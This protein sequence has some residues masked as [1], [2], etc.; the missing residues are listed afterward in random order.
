MKKFCI[1]SLSFLFISCPVFGIGLSKNKPVK[2]PEGIIEYDFSKQSQSGA[3]KILYKYVLE[4]LNKTS[5]EA[6]VFANISPRSISAFELDLNDDG[7][8]EIIGLVWAP[9]YWGTAGYSICTGKE[10]R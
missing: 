10:R 3:S 9:C 4:G 8:N 6:V 1:I 2:L 7:T 5:Q